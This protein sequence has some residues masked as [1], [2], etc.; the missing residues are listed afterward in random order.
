M[1][2]ICEDIKDILVTEGGFTFGT[3]LFISKQPSENIDVVTLYDTSGSA[4]DILLNGDLENSSFEVLVSYVGYQAAF[5]VANE[6]KDLLKEKANFT[7]SGTRYV[8]FRLENGP[9]EIPNRSMNPS[10]GKVY[11]S[12]NF[13]VKRYKI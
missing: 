2:P 6:I 8:V 12:L 1:N 4:P 13:S 5:A 7:L 10:D 9:N 3:D 11:L